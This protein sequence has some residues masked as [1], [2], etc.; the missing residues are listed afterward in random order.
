MANGIKSKDIAKMLGVSA[1]TVSLVVNGKR[2]VSDKRRS[3]IIEKIREIDGEH[4]LKNAAPMTEAIGFVVFK[5]K[6]RI[7]DES[8]FFA[9][10]LEDI[11]QSLKERDYSIKLL[12]LSS[13]MPLQEQEQV[14]QNSDCKGFI[15]W[16]TEMMKEDLNV[17]K[18]SKLPFVMLDNSFVANDVD[19]VAIN[20]MYGINK[21]VGYFHQRGHRKIGYIRSKTQINSFAERFFAYKM[22][23]TGL[24]LEL[25]PAHVVAVDYSDAGSARDMFEY[26][27]RAA[28]LPTCFASDNDLVAC[29]AVKGIK[30][31]GLKIPADISIIGFDDRPICSIVDPQLTT[32][33]IPLY[34]FGR[35]SVKILFE[36]LAEKRDYA[37]KVEFSTPLIERASVRTV[38]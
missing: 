30:K 31:F 7:I 22:A 16:A 25:N 5:R 34:E 21:V 8:P 1:S 13:N 17:L 38:I 37:I 12:Y 33:R 35:N 36:K 26:L 3:E 18:N 4:L 28:S 11:T 24:G 6:G 10:F 14:L 9:Y 15:V 27:S 20:N 32:M 23:L 19:T 29:G 2:G